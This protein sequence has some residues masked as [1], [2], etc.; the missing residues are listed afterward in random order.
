MKISRKDWMFIALGLAVLIVFYIISGPE[1]TKQV[2]NDDRHRPA[3]DVFKQTGSKKEADK[4]CPTCHNEQGGIPFPKDHPL[5]P[6]D[7]PMSC[8]LCHKLKKVTP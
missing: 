1:K 5:K 8:H 7:G 3:Y 6:K 2:P 4:T